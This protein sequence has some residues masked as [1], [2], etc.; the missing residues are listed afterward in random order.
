MTDLTAAT[1]PP[2]EGTAPAGTKPP[3]G[4]PPAQPPPA[5]PSPGPGPPPGGRPRR[6]RL[7]L[8]REA[9]FR[10]LWTGEVTSALGTA[11]GAVALPLVAVVVLDVPPL[12]LGVITASAWLPWLLIGLLAGAWVDRLPRRRVMQCCD[13][14]FVAIYL[15]VP[16]AAW[17]GL[18]TA[19]QLVVVALLSG[20][21]RVFF[22]TA[23][24]AIVPTLVAKPDLLEANV[25]LRSG[26][27][28]AEVAG[29]GLA[30]LI[31]QLLGPVSAVLAHAAS[32]LVSLLCLSRIE[33]TERP[34]ERSA[35]RGIRQE[36]AEGVR[37]V[38]G[39]RYLRVLVCFSAMGNFALSGIQAVQVLFLV[40]TVGLE[41]GGV[42]A[43]FAVVSVGGL[44]GATLA[45]RVARRWGT[46]R[47]LLYCE[48][49]AAPCILLLP[50]A[51]TQIPLAVSTLAWGVAVGGI[52]AGN[53]IS[54][55]FFQTYTPGPLLGRVRATTST[56]NYGS[57]AVGALTGGVLGGLLGLPGTIWAMCAV[58]AGAGALLLLS[59]IRPLRELPT[60]REETGA[61]P[62]TL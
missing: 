59:P 32:Y 48:L 41:P 61:E 23:Y 55:S 20:T 7:G 5:Q 14:L 60:A 54:G 53:V 1:G 33:T 2:A 11:I 6:G 35:R 42:G 39:D 30:G 16:V 22:H 21:V 51:G 43:V 26:E 34:P 8:W 50:M 44:L 27:S 13:L 28:A 19:G 58:L 10:R 18:L 37:F 3:A 17:L 24:G 47:A 38:A 52:V 29:P 9:D 36:I 12:V 25:K 46:A 45:G 15:S 4:P 56:L 49:L 62:V 31:G 40:R 57:F